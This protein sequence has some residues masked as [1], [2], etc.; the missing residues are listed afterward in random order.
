M[1]NSKQSVY[2]QALTKLKKN[3]KNKVWKPG[4]RLPT[5]KQLANN[6]GISI[7]II[8]EALHTLENQG[9][10]SIEHGRG[11]YLR[12]DPNAVNT[13]MIDYNKKV[14]LLSLLK[15]RLLVEPQQAYMCAQKANEKLSLQLDDTAQQMDQE[16]QI[17]DDFLKIDLRF[18]QLIAQGADEQS[19]KIMTQSLEPYQIESRRMTNTLPQ[20]RTKA[21]LYH[22]LIAAAVATHDA[23]EAQKLM[24]LHIESMIK[25][26]MNI[27]GKA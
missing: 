24:K 27:D 7:T 22:Q 13:D 9:I 4:E 21:A 1:A 19:L 8:R 5:I 15:A 3:I 25:P 14:P 18:H 11:I 2:E 26:L 6:L 16:M 23:E 12:N 17:G 20:M 10:I